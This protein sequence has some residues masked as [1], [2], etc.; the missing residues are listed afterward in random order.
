MSA[1]A[2]QDAR[3]EAARAGVFSAQERSAAAVSEKSPDEEGDL[4]A[5]IV[6]LRPRLVRFAGP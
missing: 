5:Q 6:G 1:F 3:L 4:A 2:S